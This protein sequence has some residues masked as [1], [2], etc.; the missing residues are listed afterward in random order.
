MTMRLEGKVAIVTGSSQGIGRAIALGFARE[1]AKLVVGDLKV[2]GAEAVAREIQGVGAEALALEADVSSE[3]SAM[4]LKEQALRRFGRVDILV[5]NA[6]I[7]LH[8]PTTQ[9]TEEEWDK[10]LDTN[11]GGNF[12]CSRAVVPQMRAQKGGRIISVA[13]AIA[14]RGAKSG[15]HYAASKAGIV[16]FVKALA[17]ELAPDGITV[18]AVCPG[19]ADTALPRGHR[20]DEELYARA[21]QI[22]L[23]RIAQ[24]G[25]IAG[26]MNFLASDAASYITGQALLV[27]GGALMP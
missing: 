3:A 10:V 5:N 16:G 18:N 22:P 17:R 15:S 12:L 1:G 4:N 6:G 2:D 9:M 25:D 21:K 24:P 19:I 8:S 13:S 7:Y 27:D 23:G 20:S 26:V 11:L 14:F